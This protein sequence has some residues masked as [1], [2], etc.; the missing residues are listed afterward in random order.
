MIVRAVT[1]AADTP[2]RRRDDALTDAQRDAAHR[3]R[4]AAR[5]VAAA[6]LPADY[7]PDAFRIVAATLL[8]AQRAA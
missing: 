3:L 1:T 7:R 5:I 6:A 8:D 2:T 4:D